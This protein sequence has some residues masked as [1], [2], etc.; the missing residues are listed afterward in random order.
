MSYTR[1]YAI[2][3]TKVSEISCLK[4]SWGS[5]PMLWEYI[6]QKYLGKAFNMADHNDGFWAVRKDPRMCRH[7]RMVFLSTFDCGLVDFELLG[8]YEQA[9]REM[10]GKI[11][12]GT[13]SEWNHFVAIAEAA[14][15]MRKKHDSRCL[16]LGLG[17]TSICDPWL[18]YPKGHTVFSIQASMGSTPTSILDEGR[19]QCQN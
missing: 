1:V 2:Y 3:K 15:D 5:A 16:G 10:S 13:K 9:C 11:A 7:D 18:G 4:N 14:K 17:C 12:Q 19:S 8:E 6:S